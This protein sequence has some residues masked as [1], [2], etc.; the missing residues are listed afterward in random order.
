[1]QK[2]YV[3]SRAKRTLSWK[4]NAVRI[5]QHKDSTSSSGDTQLHTTEGYGDVSHVLLQADPVGH[6]QRQNTPA[7]LSL[8]SYVFAG[9]N[10]FRAD[11]RQLGVPDTAWLR[12]YI[13][14]SIHR[15]TLGGAVTTIAAATFITGTQV[16][17][18]VASHSH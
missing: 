10:H 9:T 16:L 6:C 1:M 7:W 4:R 2:M 8:I 13:H 5:T 15:I 12:M 11:A 17:H 14:P 18:V 3:Y